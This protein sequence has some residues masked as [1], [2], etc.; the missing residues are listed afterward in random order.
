[1]IEVRSNLTTSIAVTVFLTC[2]VYVYCLLHSSIMLEYA[3][4]LSLY[5]I[6]LCLF[7]SMRSPMFPTSLY[8]STLSDHSHYL[9]NCL[10]C[11]QE[12]TSA[13]ASGLMSDPA[14]IY[15]IVHVCILVFE[16]TKIKF[17]PTPRVSS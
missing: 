5:C 6:K 15:Y 17:K 7:S 10:S 3:I 16:A 1:M 8:A 9:C 2:S 14:W 12:M 13:Q 11:C 4:S